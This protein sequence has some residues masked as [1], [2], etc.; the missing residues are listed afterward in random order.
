MAP[1]LLGMASNLIEVASILPMY[2]YCIIVM[3]SKI[4]QENNNEIITAQVIE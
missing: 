2:I 4:L 1:N 3:A